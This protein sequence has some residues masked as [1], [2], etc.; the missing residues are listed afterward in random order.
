M[1][2]INMAII[3]RGRR[4]KLAFELDVFSFLVLVVFTTVVGMALVY[5]L[6]KSVT[7]ILKY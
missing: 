3:T 2:P 5:W 1:S 4:L 7:E 6:N